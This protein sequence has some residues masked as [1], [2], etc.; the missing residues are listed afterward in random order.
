[1]GLPNS[2]ST[3][4][5]QLNIIAGP[6]GNIWFTANRQS[7]VL[8]FNLTTQRIQIITAG[9]TSGSGAQWI[10]LGPNNDIWFTEDFGHALA[11]VDPAR[12]LA[13]VAEVAASAPPGASPFYQNEAS[14]L[15]NYPGLNGI[16]RPVVQARVRSTPQFGVTE[17]L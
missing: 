15:A 12:V 17:F 5:S 6:D 14:L 2:K 13:H 1:A 4:A 3:Q 16:L 10:N 7:R 8:A 9:I 11:R